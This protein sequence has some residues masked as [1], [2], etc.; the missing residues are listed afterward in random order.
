MIAHH[1]GDELLL[2]LAAGRMDSGPAVPVTVHLERCNLCRGRLH[3]MQAIGGMLVEQTEP[4]LLAPDAL[5][6]TMARIDARAVTPI[7]N[8][9]RQATRY[10]SLPAGVKWPRSLHGA[11][12]SNWHWMGP[13][14][15]FSRVSLAH[16]PDASLFLLRIGPGRSLARHT[17]G[18]IEFTQ[19]L[20]GTFDDGRA[21]FGPGDFDATDAQINHQPV[22]RSGAECVCLAYVSA[23]LKFDGKLASMIG[24]W[25]GM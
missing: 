14:M 24:A 1:P 4:V 22:V 11:A 12:V 7:A 9:E 18:G 15:R 8:G 10:P 25:V 5:T 6:Q 3:R 21:V 16:E 17:H 23:P 20:C 13:G 2:A 19:V